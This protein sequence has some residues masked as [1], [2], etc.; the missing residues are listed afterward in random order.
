MQYRLS[1]IF[2]VFFVTATSLAAFG[3]FFGLIAAGAVFF[4]ALF[5]HWKDKLDSPL[6][7][8]LIVFA[9]IG[10]IVAMLVQAVSTP[11]EN[12]RLVQCTNHLQ[13][14]GKSLLIYESEHGYFPK[15]NTCDKEGQPLS[16][17]MVEILPQM[18][19]QEIY[20]RLHK[21]EP[22]NSPRNSKILGEQKVPEFIC[23]GLN[24]AEDDYSPNYIAIVGP[25]TI[26]RKDGSINLNDISNSSLTVMAIEC[27]T[28]DKHWAEPYVL[29]AEEA[30]ERMKTGKGMRIS[31]AHPSRVS[32]LFADGHVETLGTDTPISVW[33]KLLMGE[34]KHAEELHNWKEFASDPSP[35]HMTIYSFPTPKN[36]MYPASIAVWL[37]S[38]FLLFLRAWKSREARNKA[39]ATA[40]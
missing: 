16:S 34:M 12:V 17:W 28:S 5:V 38:I 22:W 20:D 30:L 32:V 39:A 23:L 2:L 15:V 19:R 1:T 21:D 37:I 29:T 18:E 35:Y 33:R 7:E 31:T 9:V 26:W 11:R 4:L 10:F 27:A 36:R 13:E 25:G 40:G 8:W 3:A 14:I 6:V 24:R